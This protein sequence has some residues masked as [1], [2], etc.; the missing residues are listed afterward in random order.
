M[1]KGVGAFIAGLICGG[2]AG[3][4]GGYFYSKKKYI[5]LADKEVA[6]IKAMQKEHDE[7]LLKHHGLSNNDKSEDNNKST[8]P[9]QKPSTKTTITPNTVKPSVDRLIVEEAANDKMVNY[10]KIASEYLNNG[11]SKEENQ[12]VIPVADI[13]ILSD[14]EFGE[15]DNSYQ[16]LHYYE[17]GIITDVDDNPVSNYKKLVGPMTLWYDKFDNYNAVYVRNTSLGVDYEI[18]KCNQ[19]W[20]DIASPAQK[21]SVLNTVGE[22][23]DDN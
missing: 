19:R 12:P 17:D 3:I 6:S 4:A 13:V 9:N 1:S 14:Q 18:L 15:S 23:D 16:T 5:D 2:A 11:S 22:E 20:N 8:R 7:W 21:A 10:Q